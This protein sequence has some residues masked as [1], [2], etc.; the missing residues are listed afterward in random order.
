MSAIPRY[1]SLG[2]RP[3][4]LPNLDEGMYNNLKTCWEYNPE[5]RLSFREILGWTYGSGEE[6]ANSLPS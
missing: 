2:A 3:M 1:L 4:K 6:Y 5:D